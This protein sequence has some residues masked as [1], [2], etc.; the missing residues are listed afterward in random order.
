ME[1]GEGSRTGNQAQVQVGSG[2]LIRALPV[3]VRPR[4]TRAKIRAAA[5]P[6][7]R[8]YYTYTLFVQRQAVDDNI[9]ERLRG[10]R[11]QR[12]VWLL[13]VGG[14]RGECGAKSEGWWF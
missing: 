11:W 13:R 4:S 3:Y 12:N 14:E 1:H 7:Y 9:L 2:S 5:E 10:R 8:Y 6:P